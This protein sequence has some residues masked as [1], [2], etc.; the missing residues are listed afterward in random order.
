M[1]IKYFTSVAKIF[2]TTF[3]S[4]LNSLQG[5]FQIRIEFFFLIYH[6]LAHKTSLN[7]FQKIP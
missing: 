1:I 6:V 4:R 7:K 5:Q 2:I 3:W